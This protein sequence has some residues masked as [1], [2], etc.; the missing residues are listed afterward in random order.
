ME[1][2]ELSFLSLL[3]VSMVEIR[4]IR[5]NWNIGK[6]EKFLKYTLLGWSLLS[7]LAF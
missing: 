2:R 5:F 1:L 4:S 6:C 7:P 3:V